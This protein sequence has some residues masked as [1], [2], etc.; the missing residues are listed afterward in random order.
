VADFDQISDDV[1]L[2][3][4]EASRIAGFSK[5]T[6]KNWRSRLGD[7]KRPKVTIVHRAIRYRTGDL[8]DWLRG[9]AGVAPGKQ[10][11][12]TKNVSPNATRPWPLRH[13][14]ERADDQRG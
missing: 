4:A 5:F 2:T 8:R 13:D 6:F 14:V 1:F 7:D 11:A 12:A 9:L 10:T 3:E